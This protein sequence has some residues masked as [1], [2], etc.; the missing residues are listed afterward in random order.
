M[1][2]SLF[3]A[4]RNNGSEPSEQAHRSLR[5]SLLSRFAWPS[6]VASFVLAISSLIVLPFSP[7]VGPTQMPLGAMLPP[8]IL[9]HSCR[10]IVSIRSSVVA[11]GYL[12]IFCSHEPMSMMPLLLNH[13]WH[14]RFASIISVLG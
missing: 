7:G 6:S 10:A 12:S 3:L 14:G 13:C 2:L 8:I 11:P 1:A 4:L 5:R 9:V